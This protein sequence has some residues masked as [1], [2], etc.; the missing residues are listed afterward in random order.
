VTVPF[1][2]GRTDATQEQ[3]DVEAFA[4]LEPRADGFR[5]WAR[6]DDKV[7]AEVRLLDTAFM[8]NLTAPE[9]TVL[10]GGLRALGVSQDGRG[11]FTDRPGTLTNDFFVNLLAVGADWSASADTENVFGTAD[12]RWTATAVDLVFGSHSQLRAI[13]E[14]YASSGRCRPTG[15]R[16][17]CSGCGGASAEAILPRTLTR[18]R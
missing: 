17:A 5:N 9:L 10:V 6:A 15:S 3:T 13:A 2:P 16:R 1:A 7:P 4:A 14:V 12:G 18:I 8:L 11:V